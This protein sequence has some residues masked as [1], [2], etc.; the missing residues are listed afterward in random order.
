[1]MAPSPVFE[2]QAMTIDAKPERL[3]EARD[4]AHRAAIQAG[5]GD[6]DC[7]QVKL[8]VSEAVANAIE[9]GSQSDGDRIRIA[10]FEAGGSLVFEVR[11]NG[12]FVA[13]PA[14]AT[15]DDESGR[16]LELLTLMMDE[17]HITSTGE[18]SLLRFAKRLDVR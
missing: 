10:A 4:W 12:T 6:A 9:H 16:G 1:M 17:V 3:E 11:D 13:P 2:D 18:G 8:A 15:I 5:L 14:R 7:Y